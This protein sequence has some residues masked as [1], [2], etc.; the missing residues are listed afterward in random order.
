V[1]VGVVA[2][3][4]LAEIGAVDFIVTGLSTNLTPVQ[5]VMAW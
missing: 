1:L 5:Y 2:G 3:T 4:T